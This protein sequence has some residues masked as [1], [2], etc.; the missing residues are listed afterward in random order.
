M[1]IIR[2]KFW[3]NRDFCC[4][5]SINIPLKKLQ[6]TTSR[7]SGPGGQSVNKS[8][9]KVQIRFNVKAA[10]WLTQDVK[11]NF[12]V[13]NKAKLTQKGDFVV[14]SDE[15]SSQSDNKRACIQKIEEALRKAQEYKPFVQLTFLEQIEENKSQEEILQ[16]K[17]SRREKRRKSK[18]IGYKTL[19]DF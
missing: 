7:S 8:E 19:G 15:F 13:V 1:R 12:L 2:G 3:P 18:N 4:F 17:I 9:T 11:N 6:I 5:S 14:A 16:Y 10:D